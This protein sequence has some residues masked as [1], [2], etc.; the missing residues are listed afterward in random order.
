[1][2]HLFQAKVQ[3]RGVNGRGGAVPVYQHTRPFFGKLHG[4]GALGQVNAERS[5]SALLEVPE[6]I[7]C[8]LKQLK[9][10]RPFL[11]EY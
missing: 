8:R 3:T 10:S 2:F 1:M 4:P 11:N 5:I 9:P 6:P 7:F